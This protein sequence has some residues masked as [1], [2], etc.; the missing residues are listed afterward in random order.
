MQ[1]TTWLRP[2]AL[3]VA[4]AIHDAEELL[5]MARWSRQARA[6]LASRYPWIPDRVLHVLDVL[7]GQIPIGIGLVGV[8]MTAAAMAGA[9]TH[10]RSR[11]YQAALLGFGAHGVGHMV[12]SIAY[13]GY[14][15]GVATSP[16]LVVFTVVWW[17]HLEADGVAGDVDRVLSMATLLAPVAPA[18]HVLARRIIRAARRGRT[19]APRAS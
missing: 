3:S 4:W 13:R 16:A 1:R 18:A 6:R 10:G 12:Q 19:D 14:T 2:L 9:A 7:P 17:R 15:P 11:F 5:T 8:P